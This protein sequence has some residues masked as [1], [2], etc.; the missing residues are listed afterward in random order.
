MT[1]YQN[2][3]VVNEA[4]ATAD[5]FATAYEA[6]AAPETKSNKMLPVIII[7][8]IAVVAI[9]LG[10]LL[11]GAGGGKFITRDQG[12]V[13][14]PEGNIYLNGK[15][16]A[17]L[18][19]EDVYLYNAY[20]GKSALAECMG[21]GDSGYTLFVVTKKGATEI[22]SDIDVVTYSQ[23]REYVVYRDNTDNGENR[24]YTWYN[25]ANKKSETIG[26]DLA[27]VKLSPDGKTVA[28]AETEE[29]D[30]GIE[31]TT[32][33]KKFGGKAT[34]I[35]LKN[36]T[37]ALVSDGAKFLYLDKAT[38]NGSD[39]YRSVNKKEPQK[40]CGDADLEN[41]NDDHTEVIYSDDK[42]NYYWADGKKEGVKIAKELGDLITPNSV[43]DYTT[44]KGQV[45][46]YGDNNIGY[47]DGKEMFKIASKVG[48]AAIAKDGKTMYFTKYNDDGACELYYVKNATAK[49]YEPVKVMEDVRS[50]VTITPDGK[51]AYVLTEDN[52]LIVCSGKK[53][54]DKIADDVAGISAMNAKGICYFTDV[55]GVLYATKGKDKVKLADDINAE[56]SGVVGRYGNYFYYKVEGDL[57]FATGTKAEKVK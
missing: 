1:E 34:Q 10:I 20:D 18:D 37:P 16:V 29:K 11:L 12:F 50:S 15:K 33:V 4:A 27:A 14:G 28:Y 24:T 22:A 57:Y 25:V 5:P 8:A 53:K 45:Y 54:G 6:P 44:F 26:E 49:K 51:K 32:F 52:E 38:E 48:G 47:F 9:I 43:I 35:E 13:K 2:E 30:D 39:L 21:E 7:A 17:Q 56:D 3:Q 40:V 42:G 41:Y 36:A 31:Y 46:S 23:N 19:Y 55:D